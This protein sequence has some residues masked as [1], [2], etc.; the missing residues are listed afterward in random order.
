MR[1]FY[2]LICTALLCLTINAQAQNRTNRMEKG[3]PWA[4]VDSLVNIGKPESAKL[5]V[6]D[7]LKSAE[8]KKQADEIIEAATLSYRSG[9]ISFAEMSQFLGQA[10]AIR[11]NYLDVLNQYNHSAIQFNYFNTK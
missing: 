8:Q 3:T 11:Q 7:I 10:I 2:F 6:A 4:K 5:I 1:S 9:E